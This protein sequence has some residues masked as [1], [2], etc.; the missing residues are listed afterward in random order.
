MI[1]ELS[2]GEVRATRTAEPD[3]RD[4]RG[5]A[6]T[7]T[8][9]CTQDEDGAD[10]TMRDFLGSGAEDGGVPKPQIKR[11]NISFGFVAFVG[12]G[13]RSCALDGVLGPSCA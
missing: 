9:F 12:C 6:G 10:E 2:T 13:V 5:R 1:A 8:E 3:V 4:E 11:R 7:A